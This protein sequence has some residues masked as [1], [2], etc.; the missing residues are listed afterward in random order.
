MQ[1]YIIRA[2]NDS[3]INIIVAY[4]NST[5]QYYEHQYLLGLHRSFTAHELQLDTKQQIFQIKKNR[6]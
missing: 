2:L 1:I 4:S 6:F 5:K 3:I